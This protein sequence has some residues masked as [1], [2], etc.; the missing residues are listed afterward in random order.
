M[1]RPHPLLI[2]YLEDCRGRIEVNE[3]KHV[4]KKKKLY[5]SF[6]RSVDKALEQKEQLLE[7]LRQQQQPANAITTETLL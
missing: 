3:W 6:L 7:R 1:S 2:D 5:C 4:A